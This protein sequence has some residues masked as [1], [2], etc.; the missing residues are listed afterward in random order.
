MSQ[1]SS[2]KGLQRSA[3]VASVWLLLGVASLAL[4]VHDRSIPEL[5]AFVTIDPLALRR[6]SVPD[7]EVL[8]V[9][10]ICGRVGRDAL[11]LAKR[12]NLVGANRW[13]GL[14]RKMASVQLVRS[15]GSLGRFL[16]HT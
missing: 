8:A 13:K 14:E 6:A 3:L 5:L 1:P 12:S 11:A 2:S 15:F 4:K 16:L 10:P 9:A 7:Q